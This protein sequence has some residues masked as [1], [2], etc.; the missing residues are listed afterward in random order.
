MAEIHGVPGEWARVKGMVFGL[1]PLF[2]G[3]FGL[4]FACA[5]TLLSPVFGALVLLVSAIYCYLTLLNG[6]HH[7]E[8]FFKGAR[9]EERV[10]SLLSSLPDGY[11]IFN[12]FQA[13]GDHV[14]HVVVGPTGVFS[15][16]TKFWK[17]AVTV[18][19][20]RILAGGQLPSRDPVVQ[21]QKESKLIRTELERRGL[22]YTVTPLLAFASNT[23]TGAIMELRGVVVV[24]SN[25]LQECIMNGREVL[26]APELD[27]LVRIME[28]C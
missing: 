28:T 3:V 7:V 15:V 20:N 23:F 6:L 5:L 1:W 16:E 8:R 27:R 10:A 2:L 13:G 24:N 21:A 22:K 19:E 25:R 26:D 12:D 18:E 9:G 11:H 4:G 17:D 14:D